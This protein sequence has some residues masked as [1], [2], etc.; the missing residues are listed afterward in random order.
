MHWVCF[1]FF[2]LEKEGTSMAGGLGVISGCLAG[3]W[4]ARGFLPN[5]IK[6]GRHAWASCYSF[7]R[8]AQGRMRLAEGCR[9]RRANVPVA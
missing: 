6:T 4:G 1:F 5:K 2:W 9:R 7:L 3:A 8:W